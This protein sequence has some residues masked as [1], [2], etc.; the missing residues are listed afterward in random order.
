MR[1]GQFL[2]LLCISLRL[3]VPA[4]YMVESSASLNGVWPLVLCTGEGAWTGRSHHHAHSAA[5]DHGASRDHE[6]CPFAVL[7]AP[8][9]NASDDDAIHAQISYV[10]AAERPLAAQWRPE[11]AAPPPPASGPPALL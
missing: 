7:Y 1:L 11:L 4:G 6:S 2:A 10:A 9:S 8:A 5:H 3:A